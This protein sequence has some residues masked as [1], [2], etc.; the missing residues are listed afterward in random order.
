MFNGVC[1]ICII[2]YG[3]RSKFR[4][5]PN[6]WY[7]SRSREMIWI[8]QIR[9][10]IRNTAC[11][12]FICIQPVLNPS[13]PA[14]LLLCIPP[15]LHSSCSASLLFCIPP[16]LHPSCS[17]SLLSCIPFVL[18]FKILTQIQKNIAY[19]GYTV[20]GSVAYANDFWPIWIQLRGLHLA[21][22][23]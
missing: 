23:T 14:S 15:V 22:D 1:W 2:W 12:L 20:I 7:A 17:V 19:D 10:W 13:C 8:L 6:L 18:H 21:P 9:I 5:Q 4:I 11:I 3:S 16:V